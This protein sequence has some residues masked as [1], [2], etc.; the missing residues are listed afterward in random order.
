M[1]SSSHIGKFSL[2]AFFLAGM[3]DG[4]IEFVSVSCF[5]VQ[6][7]PLGPHNV[8]CKLCPSLGLLLHNLDVV[9]FLS[10][11]PVL[12]TLLKPKGYLV[13]KAGKGPGSCIRSEASRTRRN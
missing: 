2:I 8:L 10:S 6:C 12:A 3:G 5:V 1:I 9:L 13:V 7:C 11:A 4:A